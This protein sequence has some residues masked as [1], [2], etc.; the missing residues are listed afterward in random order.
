MFTTHFKMT[1]HPFSENTPADLLLRDDRVTQGL[2]RLQY[3]VQAGTIGLLTGSTG[4]GKSSLIKL[5]LRSLNQNQLR[6]VYIHMTRLESNAFLKMMVTALGEV[7]K[8][9]K[10]RVFMQ[11]LDKART[12]ES[13]ML[14]VIDEA[15]LLDEGALTD[16][17][18][19]VSSALQDAPPLKILLS[20]QEL[21]REHLKRASCAD[22]AN[23]ISVR[24]H[25]PPLSKDQTAAYIDFHLQQAGA[26]EKLFEPEVKS[27]IHD[28]TRGIP[29][30]INN[31]ATACLIKAA[32]QKAQR[33]GDDI[34][35]IALG[36]FQLP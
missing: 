13:P 36:E 1:R 32:V 27:L 22:L 21:I 31:L 24:Y 28:Y 12:I 16:L 26:S 9:G 5:F 17:R 35:Q 7:P 4:V 11:V 3:L 6:F 19:L 2:A 25:M 20:S 33:I 10:E 23:R 18:L 15:H 29:R 30:Q 14:V 8:H 34:F